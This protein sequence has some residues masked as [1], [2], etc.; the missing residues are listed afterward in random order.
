VST[1]P[2]RRVTRLAQT[3]EKAH[4]IAV[5]SDGSIIPRVNQKTPIDVKERMMSHFTA[6]DEVRSAPVSSPASTDRDSLLIAW[7]RGL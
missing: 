1:L 3:A 2:N 5:K 7:A 6:G 4:N